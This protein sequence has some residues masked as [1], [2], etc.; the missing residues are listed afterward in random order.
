MPRPS[1]H[2]RRRADST[3]SRLPTERPRHATELVAAHLG[4]ALDVV[5]VVGGDGTVA[6]VAEA[7]ARHADVPIAILPTGTTNVVAREYRPRPHPGGGRAHLTSSRTQPD[8]G[9]A[10]RQDGRA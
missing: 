2:A 5:A 4:E 9:V 7:L 1:S 10:R 6:E 3:S 8:H